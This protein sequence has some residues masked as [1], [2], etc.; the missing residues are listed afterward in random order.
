MTWGGRMGGRGVGSDGYR[1]AGRE[2]VCGRTS[3]RL[4]TP[5][6]FSLSQ[7]SLSK[8]PGKDPALASGPWA[9][10]DRTNRV[11]WYG[12]AMWH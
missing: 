11:E 8:R 9:E 12:K 4:S 7:Y 1:R 10:T 3:L 6:F 5:S 2:F